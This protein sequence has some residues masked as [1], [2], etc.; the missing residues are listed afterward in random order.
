MKEYEKKLTTAELEIKASKICSIKRDRLWR[1]VKEF[2]S[3]RAR[4]LNLG[5]AA[6][7]FYAKKLI[8][9]SFFGF[10]ITRFFDV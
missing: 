8:F 10:G 4:E 5:L 3:E 6:L 7:T 2:A 1:E 9:M